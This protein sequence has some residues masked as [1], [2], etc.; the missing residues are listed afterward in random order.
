VQVARRTKSKSHVR[1]WTPDELA[2]ILAKANVDE[3][4]F[5]RVAAS[6]GLRFGELVGLRWSDVSFE[7]ARLTVAQQFTHGAF[8]GLK[9]DNA[10]RTV[11]LASNIV[12][13]LKLWKLRCPPSEQGLVFPSPDGSALDSSNFHH[14]MWRP[15][16]ARAGV[17][18]GTFHALRHSL[19]QR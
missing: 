13:E 7:A 16:L 2:A 1:A 10:R 14:R 11:P 18:H 6:T 9:T 5:I 17:T 15:L 19:P 12:K 4:L 8:S 3:A